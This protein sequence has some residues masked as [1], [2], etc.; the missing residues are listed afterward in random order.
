MPL[1][2]D[3]PAPLSGGLLPGKRLLGYH[4]TVAYALKIA[5]PMGAGLALGVQRARIHKAR[6]LF[7]AQ[8]R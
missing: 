2:N 5:G 6:G 8:D 7:E 1:Q 4:G 3:P